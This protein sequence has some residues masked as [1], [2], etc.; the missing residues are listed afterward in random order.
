MNLSAFFT[1]Q[2][3]WGLLTLAVL[4]WYSTVTVYVA[5]RGFADIR[6]MLRKLQSTPSP[7]VAAPSANRPSAQT[8][9][10]STP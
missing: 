10:H 6:A 9:P 3:F 2:P 4:A 7:D 5:V 1:H 8:G